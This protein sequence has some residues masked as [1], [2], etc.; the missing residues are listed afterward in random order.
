MPARS[1]YELLQVAPTA[2]HAVIEAAYRALM[3][4]HHP[5]QAGSAGDAALAA[6]INHAYNAVRSPERRADTDRQLESARRER[7]QATQARLAA[8]HQAPTQSRSATLFGWLGWLV[9]VGVC[10]VVLAVDRPE[11]AP[12]TAARTADILPPEPELD[13]VGTSQPDP[14][15]LETAERELGRSI[16]QVVIPPVAPVASPS[17]AATP[18]AVAPR[19]PERTRPAPRREQRPAPLR[20]EQQPPR[21]FLEREGYIY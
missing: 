7:A 3:K 18:R 12:V 17:S 16:P 13:P 11:P 5:D 6:E 14:S 2:H 21:D 8:L 20:R 1:P 4:R 10:A 15:T 9:A 19:A